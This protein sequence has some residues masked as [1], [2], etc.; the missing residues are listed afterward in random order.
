MST[1]KPKLPNALSEL[2]VTVYQVRAIDVR[3]N[4]RIVHAYETEEAAKAAIRTMKLKSQ[5]R[6]VYVPVPNQPNEFWGI[7]FERP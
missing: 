4:V 1:T 5:T 3:G 7:N 6:Y 2:P